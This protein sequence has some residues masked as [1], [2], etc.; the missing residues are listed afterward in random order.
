MS[1][2]M[3]AVGF[4]ASRKAYRPEKLSC[5]S[6]GPGCAFYR[7]PV[8]CLRLLQQSC[9]LP[10]HLLT[11]LCHT[12]AVNNMQSICRWFACSRTAIQVCEA[13][14]RNS[15]TCP[16][17]CVQP[18]GLWQHLCSFDTPCAGREGAGWHHQV[19]R[20]GEHVALHAWG[21][22]HTAFRDLC[23]KV[24]C[25]RPARLFELRAFRD[26]DGLCTAAAP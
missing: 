25:E 23:S 12:E 6:H 20:C 8:G 16:P 15:T 14:Y 18:G 19:W 11:R 13:G 7:I 2:P 3:I 17:G 22:L 5:T 26:P 9:Q 10:R 24:L 21:A 1:L 4:A